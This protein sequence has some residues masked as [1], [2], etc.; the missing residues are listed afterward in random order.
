MTTAAPLR[1]TLLEPRTV[2]IEVLD[3]GFREFRAEGGH[4]FGFAGGAIDEGGGGGGELEGG[5]DLGDDVGGG[6]GREDRAAGVGHGLGGGGAEA[7]VGDEGLQV[8][9]GGWGSP[10]RRG[11]RRWRTRGGR[12]RWQTRWVPCNAT[13]Y[14]DHLT[15]G[16]GL[17]FFPGSADMWIMNERRSETRMLCADMVEVRWWDRSR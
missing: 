5:D 2:G 7:A 3:A 4:G 8:V 1:T 15:G 9:A 13:V 11:G 16:T 10:R 17:N 12:R 6:G 14:P